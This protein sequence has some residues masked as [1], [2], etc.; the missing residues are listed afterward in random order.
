MFVLCLL[1]LILTACGFE[2]VYTVNEDGTYTMDVYAYRNCEEFTDENSMYVLEVDGIDY[3]KYKCTIEQDEDS[4]TPTARYYCVPKKG[5]P[6][7]FGFTPMHEYDEHMEI[8]AKSFKSYKGLKSF[9][10]DFY[11]VTVNFP[12]KVRDTSGIILEDGKS[13][14]WD[15]KKLSTDEVY[16]YTE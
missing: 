7:N 8:T 14:R 16:A 1:S 15:F 9:F 12:N 4:T 2:H 11:W 3:Y 6:A 13:V 5:V 10:S